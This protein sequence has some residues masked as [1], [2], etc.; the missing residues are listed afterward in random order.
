MGNPVTTFVTY[1][2]ATFQNLDR[3][4]DKFLL[5]VRNMEMTLHISSIIRS[6]YTQIMTVTSQT[7]KITKNIRNMLEFAYLTKIS[8]IILR[9]KIPQHKENYKI[10][11]SEKIDELDS[12]SGVA[13][14]THIFY[15][16]NP[17]DAAQQYQC[18]MALPVL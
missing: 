2:Y 10:I 8:C 18:D 15:Y 1:Y 17:N 13:T 3:N 11:M 14:L 16:K 9:K 6:N 4:W 5:S 12:C 7:Q